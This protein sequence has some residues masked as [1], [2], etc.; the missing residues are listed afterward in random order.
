MFKQKILASIAISAT[1]ACAAQDK[2]KT[3]DDQGI[4]LAHAGKYKEAIKSYSDA[5]T[6]DPTD[7]KAFVNRGQAESAIGELNAALQD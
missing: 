1:M 5:I 4:E 2:S 7:A 3:L 6:A